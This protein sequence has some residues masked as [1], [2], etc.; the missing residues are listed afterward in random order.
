MSK[1]AELQSLLLNRLFDPTEEIAQ[2]PPLIT[3]KEKTILTEQNFITI[4]GLP[5]SRKTTFMNLFLASAIKEQPIFDIAVKLQP[6]DKI[7]II[8]TEQSKS[9][10]YKQYKYLKNVCWPNDPNKKINSYL[11]REDEPATILNAISLIMEEQKPKLLFVDNLTELVLNFNDIAECKKVIQ[12]FK[13]IT[14]KYNCGVVCL[15]HLNKGNGLTQGNLGSFADK[16]S[17]SILKVELDRETQNSTLLADRL[18][19]AGNFEPITIYFNDQTKQ[20]ERAESK[21]PP[22]PKVKFSMDQFTKED[23]NSRLEITF[24]F[25]KEFSYKALCEQLKKVFGRGD[26]AIKQVVIPY[27]IGKKLISHKNEIYQRR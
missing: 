21:P 11:F 20:Y 14:A 27:L 17:Q 23:L 4:S 8:D 25:Q 16:G 26:N 18:R 2:P 9:D 15:I 19:S 1:K 13:T 22:E 5:K 3:I 12:F 10:F 24:E 6:E 7:V